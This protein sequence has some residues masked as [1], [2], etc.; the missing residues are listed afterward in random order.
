M[1]EALLYLTE[2]DPW[3]RNANLPLGHVLELAHK[4]E[5]TCDLCEAKKGDVLPIREKAS[6]PFSLGTGR[7]ASCCVKSIACRLTVFLSGQAIKRFL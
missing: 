3:R 7:W 5:G 6:D 1:I 2:A 4:E